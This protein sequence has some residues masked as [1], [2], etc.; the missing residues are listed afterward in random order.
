MDRRVGGSAAAHR[1]RQHAARART[2]GQHATP[3][4]PSIARR[5]T[6]AISPVE[7]IRRRTVGDTVGP[8]R[9]RRLARRDRPVDRR[10]A[11]VRRT[12]VADARARRGGDV[13]PDFVFGRRFLRH[14]DHAPSRANAEWADGTPGFADDVVHRAGKSGFGREPH[15]RRD[16]AAL[17][18]DQRRGSAIER[19]RRGGRDR[20]F[21]RRRAR[22]DERHERPMA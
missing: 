14:R 13:G 21:D 16:H 20:E 5:H 7:R 8:R 15:G 2:L 10:R 19:R 12:R 18:R 22:L 17:V 6:V 9:P 1:T 11:A 3:A 4:N